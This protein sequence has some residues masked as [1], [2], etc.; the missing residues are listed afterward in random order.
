M[1]STESKYAVIGFHNLTRM[2]IVLSI[3]KF[4]VVIVVIAVIVVVAP[5]ML[6]SKCVCP[7]VQD[8]LQ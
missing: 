2:K 3:F 6:E 8:I 4:V 5:A 1:R 7:L